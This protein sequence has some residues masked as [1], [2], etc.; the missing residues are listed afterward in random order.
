MTKRKT[1][2]AYGVMGIGGS[3]ICLLLIPTLPLIALIYFL[4]KLTD[5]VVKKL[6]SH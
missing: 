2:A 4:W 1:W 6:E 3:L 5:K